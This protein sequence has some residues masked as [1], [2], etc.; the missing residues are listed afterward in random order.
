MGRV[1]IYPPAVLYLASLQ[2]SSLAVFV[3]D[4][5]PEDRNCDRGSC[6]RGDDSPPDFVTQTFSL[7]HEICQECQVQ[8]SCLKTLKI[9]SRPYVAIFRQTCSL[10]FARK[11]M[12]KYSGFNY[13]V[14]YFESEN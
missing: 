3:E 14:I 6:K 10:K 4:L 12:S 7:F 9:I 13:E 1:S 5:R 2:T 8:V 11:Q